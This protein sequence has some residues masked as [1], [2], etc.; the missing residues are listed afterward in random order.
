MTVKIQ[1]FNGINEEQIPII[2]LTKSQ[3]KTTGTAT[4]LFVFPSVFKTTIWIEN[5][6]ALKKVSLHYKNKEIIT[7][8]ISLYFYKG[9]PF[10]IKCIFLFK[11]YRD[12][13][14]FLNLMYTYSKETG[15]YF[16]KDF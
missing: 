4:F 2:R 16:S 5:K 1:F 13:F 14:N 7:N 15:L 10:L 8:H 6:E 9:K 3:D 12:W 11:N